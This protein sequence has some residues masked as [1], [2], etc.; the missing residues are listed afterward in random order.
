MLLS[1]AEA[2][3]KDQGDTVLSGIKSQKDGELVFVAFFVTEL[4][5]QYPKDGV[6]HVTRCRSFSHRPGNEH[7]PQGPQEAGRGV[8]AVLAGIVHFSGASGGHTDLIHGGK[9]H[10]KG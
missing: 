8:G 7:G 5:L 3:P 10:E 1:L 2:W 6:W 9:K 4:L